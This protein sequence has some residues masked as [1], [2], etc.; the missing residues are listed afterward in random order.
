[1]KAGLQ[2]ICRAVKCGIQISLVLIS[3]NVGN[4]I[5]PR[6][7]KSSTILVKGIRRNDE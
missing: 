7:V 2:C 4:V 5:A 1:M 3:N 6:F